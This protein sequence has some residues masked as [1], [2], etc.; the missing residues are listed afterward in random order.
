MHSGIVVNHPTTTD[1]SLL[2]ISN[3]TKTNIKLPIALTGQLNYSKLEL[4]D[5]IKCSYPG[6]L[7]SWLEAEKKCLCVTDFIKEE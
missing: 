2:T 6:V 5:Q 1:P 7:I 4:Y 3:A